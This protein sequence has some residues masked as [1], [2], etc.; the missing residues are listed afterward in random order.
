MHQQCA[1]CGLIGRCKCGE[2]LFDKKD[3]AAN[4]VKIY[5][6]GGYNEGIYSD[7]GSYDY[8]PQYDFYHT[9][10]GCNPDKSYGDHTI[11]SYGG[12]PIKKEVKNDKALLV[13]IGL[14]AIV[15][16]FVLFIVLGLTRFN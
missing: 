3:T 9:G 10:Q 15:L 13:F 8:Y 12:Y 7:G 1:K 16:L 14:L 4:Q 11:K 5:K 6:G 2:H